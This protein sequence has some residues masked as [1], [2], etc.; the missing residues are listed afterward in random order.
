MLIVPLQPVPSQTLT[1]LL[2]NQNCRINV[3]Q[4]AFGLYFDLTVPTLSVSPLVAGVVCRNANRLVRYAYLGFI[5]DFE[6]FDQLN[7]MSPSDPDYTGLGSR[8]QLVYLEA[9]DLIQGT[10]A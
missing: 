5:G 3:Y 10:T 4:K 7:T 2:A 8:F 9:V 1:V 6:F